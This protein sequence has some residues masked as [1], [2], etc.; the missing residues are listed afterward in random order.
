VRYAGGSGIGAGAASRRLRACRSQ[1]VGQRK[2][3]VG[4][5]VFLGW[6]GA[7][8]DGAAS[9]N[10][11]PVA[12]RCTDTQRPTSVLQVSFRQPE[13]LQHRAVQTGVPIEKS[14]ASACPV[15]P[16]H[17]GPR[18]RAARGSRTGSSRDPLRP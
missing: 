17:P 6:T 7:P 13:L 3:Q 4:A 11:F 2:M 5:D 14:G 16:R 18:V 8:F 1:L 9:S 10:R 12:R 15:L